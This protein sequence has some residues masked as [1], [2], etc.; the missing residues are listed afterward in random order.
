M[1]DHPTMRRWPIVAAV[2]ATVA[3]ATAAI[4][5]RTGTDDDSAPTAT[6]HRAV[7]AAAPDPRPVGQAEAGPVGRDEAGA[8]AVAVR[9]ATASQR[10]LY[11]TDDQVAAEVTDIAT[12]D[13]GPRM[14][15]D[16]V[17]EIRSAR[18]QL[19]ISP[20]RVWWLVRPM[21]SKVERANEDS[22]RVSV[23]IVTVLSAPEV[24]APQ[25]EW[26]TITVDLDWTPDGWRVDDVRET[27]GPTPMTGPRDDPWNAVPFDDALAGFVRLDGEALQP[28]R[29][30]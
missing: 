26:M 25:S 29:L 16:T 21:A 7:P 11:M 22:A 6:E 9:V 30:P 3:L 15:E 1:Q 2:V 4:L 5:T 20:G 18:G 19:G 14:A 23:W 28:A 8:A 27:A 17:A 24:A 13:A 10:W 12:A